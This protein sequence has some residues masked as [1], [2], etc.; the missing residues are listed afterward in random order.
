MCQEKLVVPSF[1]NLHPLLSQQECQNSGD[2]LAD[3][4]QCWPPTTAGA[5]YPGTPFSGWGF[6]SPGLACPAGHTRACSATASGGADWAVQFTL[7]EG[8]TAVGCCPT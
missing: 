2:G 7:T 5:A 8:E 1:S 6:Y 3:A 4:Q